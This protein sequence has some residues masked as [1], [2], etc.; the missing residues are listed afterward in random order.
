MVKYLVGLAAVGFAGYCIVS[1]AG[2]INRKLADARKGQ[3]AAADPNRPGAIPPGDVTLVPFEDPL[4]FFRVMAPGTP[5]PAGFG[6][7]TLYEI[8]RC[9]QVGS[10]ARHLRLQAYAE[11][12]GG[13]EPNTPRETLTW[14]VKKD[15]N[16]A[17]DSTLFP[18][19]RFS[20]PTAGVEA[21][22]YDWEWRGNE[23]RAVRCR[24]LLVKKWLYTAVAHGLPGELD[25]P[26]VDAFL[27]TF[28]VTEK[29]LAHPEG[30]ALRP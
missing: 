30:G 19:V 18:K 16:V 28:E 17:N 7:Y 23:A 10:D 14:I 25:A 4:G 11:F 27:E 5:V 21:A 20:R 13:D 15:P 8:G 1:T 9:F 2:E 29:A 26:D 6:R 12:V 3:L 24:S 22:E